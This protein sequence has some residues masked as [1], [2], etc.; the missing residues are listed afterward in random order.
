M[1]DRK[2]NPAGQASAKKQPEPVIIF[3]RSAVPAVFVFAAAL[4]L[5]AKLLSSGAA[6]LY[7]AAPLSTLALC[8]GVMVYSA[9]MGKQLPGKALALSLLAGAFVGLACMAMSYYLA[10]EA[11]GLGSLL[12]LLALA[13]ASMLGCVLGRSFHARKRRAR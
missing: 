12:R 2:K 9:A 13:A 5:F 6:S 8:L 1:R 3:L 7:A 11:V 4:F 10:P